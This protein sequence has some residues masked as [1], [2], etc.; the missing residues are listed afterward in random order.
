MLA[1]DVAA[2]KSAA[3]DRV[4]V[5]SGAL[6]HATSVLLGKPR[7]ERPLAFVSHG[8][9]D[10]ILRFAGAERLVSRLEESGHDVAFHPFDGGH[11]IPPAISQALREFFAPA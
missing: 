10:R 6:P 8:R 11:E 7:K 2:Q 1:L 3:V 5:L 4:A 9:P